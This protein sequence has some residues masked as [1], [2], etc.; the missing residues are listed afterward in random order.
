MIRLV[1]NATMTLASLRSKLEFHG[2]SFLVAF[3]SD[4]FDT[5][6][7]LVTYVTWIVRGFYEETASVEFKLYRRLKRGAIIRFV[8]SSCVSVRLSVGAL[9]FEP[10]DL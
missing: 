6:N 1:I 4:T 8:A 2:S 3:S 9:Q 5:P 10:F 7:F